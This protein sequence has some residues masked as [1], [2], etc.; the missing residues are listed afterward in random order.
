VDELLVQDHNRDGIIES[1][2]ILNY[3]LRSGTTPETITQILLP[4]TYYLWVAPPSL[5]TNSSYTASINCAPL[6]AAIS[7]VVYNDWNNNGVRNNG[8][9]GLQGF[10]VFIDANHDGTWESGET[11]A[12]TDAW[13]NFSFTNLA[14]DSYNVLVAPQGGYKPTNPKTAMTI[15]VK[16]GQSVSGL[17]FGQIRI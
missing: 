5:G 12:L 6:P 2:D 3:P 16:S 9:A 17:T 1:N 4:G 7:G 15:V 10:R 11:Y 14:P 13:G 8:E